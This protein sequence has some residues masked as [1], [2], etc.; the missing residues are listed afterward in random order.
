MVREIRQLLSDATAE[1]G[2]CR[3]CGQDGHRS[4]GMDHAPQQLR[5]PLLGLGGTSQRGDAVWLAGKLRCCRQL[6]RGPKSR[7]CPRWDVLGA[8]DFAQGKSKVE[9][10]APAKRLSRCHRAAPTP[11]LGTWPRCRQLWLPQDPP[12]PPQHLPLGR[13]C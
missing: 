10:T 4:L 9:A 5:S 3:S 1:P 7:L 12:P 8:T 11:G 2:P 6:P 13:L